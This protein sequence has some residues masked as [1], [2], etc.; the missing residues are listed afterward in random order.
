M[1]LIELIFH[2]PILVEYDDVILERS[3][4]VRRKLYDNMLSVNLI[5]TF[6]ER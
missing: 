2:N 5:I 3:G 6:R 1:G 4:N